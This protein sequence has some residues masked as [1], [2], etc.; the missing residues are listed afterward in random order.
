MKIHTFIRKINKFK[1]EGHKAFTVLLKNNISMYGTDYDLDY[2]NNT[3]L[4]TL[5]YVDFKTKTTIRVGSFH[6]KDLIYIYPL[7]NGDD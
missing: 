7:N 1:K 4:I 3:D 6:L 5:W 2:V